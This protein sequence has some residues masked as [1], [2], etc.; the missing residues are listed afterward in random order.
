MNQYRKDIEKLYQRIIKIVSKGESYLQSYYDLI[1]EY[2]DYGK[3]NILQD[4]MAT[5]F[6]IDTTTYASIDIFKKTTFKKLASFTESKSNI[7]LEQLFKNKNVY[8]LGT[9]FFDLTTSQYLGDIKQYDTST[10]SKAMDVY[11]FYPQFMRS[12]IPTFVESPS[13]TIS[14]KQGNVVYFQNKL[15]LCVENYTWNK[16]NRITPTYSEYWTQIYPGTQ[17][18]H[19]VTTPTSLEEKYS[20]SIDILRNYYY[21]DYSGNNYIESN[22]IDEYFE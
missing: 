7:S 3:T 20:K 10:I 9:Q 19:T 14:Y 12:A 21:I 5:K 1:D 6:K 4:V 22:Y 16:L 2:V 17:S 15:W 13:F 18:I 11:T 8:S